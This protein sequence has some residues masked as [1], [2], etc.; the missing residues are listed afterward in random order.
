MGEAVYF[1]QID[2]RR[3]HPGSHS[4]AQP[5]HLTLQKMVRSRIQRL[6]SAENRN[7]SDHHQSQNTD[8]DQEP[9][10]EKIGSA[11]WILRKFDSR[12]QG[13]DGR[14]LLGDHFHLR[15]Y[16][17]NHQTPPRRSRKGSPALAGKVAVP[18]GGCNGRASDKRIC[19]SY[20]RKSLRGS[21]IPLSSISWAVVIPYFLAMPRGFPP[22]ERDEQYPPSPEQVSWWLPE[23]V[24]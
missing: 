9:L 10:I 4:Q 13:K 23:P 5:D 16:L 19:N 11:Y 21:V 24:H 7:Q 22:V 18:M 15:K 3:K 12:A 8:N 17:A 2:Q 6:G 1:I 20:R 14:K